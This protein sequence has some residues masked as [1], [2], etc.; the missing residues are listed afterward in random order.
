[1][2]TYRPGFAPIGIPPEVRDYVS[3]E[4]RKIHEALERAYPGVTFDFRHVAPER[5]NAGDVFLADGTNWNPG[6]GV[7]LYR[8]NAANTAWVFIEP[9][10]VAAA[11]TA[12]LADT[13][14]AHDASAI[15][16]VPAGTI[17]ATDVQAAINELDGDLTAHLA[18]ATDAH[19]ASAISSVPAGDLAATDVQAALNELDSEKQP[20]DAT[21]TA[22]AAANWAANALP[23]GTGADTLA[24]TSFA[25][26]T[27]PARSSAGNLEAKTITDFGLSIIDDAAASDARTTLGLVI[28]TDVQAYDAD[29]LSWAGV[30]RA[31]GFDTFTATPSSANLLALLT[32]ETGSG[33]AV[34][35][36]SPT[37]SGATLDG[38]TNLTGGQIAFPATQSASS[39]ANTLD[40]YEEGTWTPVLTFGTPGDLSVTYSSQAGTYTKIGRQVTVIWNITTSAF[41]HTT[42]SGTCNV[43]GLPFTNNATVSA[44]GALTWQGITKAGYTDIS[45]QV[46]TSA[47]VITM[48]ACASAS[49]A[50]VV[51]AADMPTGGSVILRGTL[52]Y[53]V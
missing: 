26:N 38:T 43:T 1:L 9:T 39:D 42:A 15:S 2:S 40:D 7:G 46:F 21:L 11:L 44:T 31:S 45:A 8:R 19:D 32:D 34:F 16:N 25:A 12:H 51:A 5:F 53:H 52:T 10:T 4:L 28:G 6:E 22:L 13:V 14:D 30:T 36:T 27:F 3:R 33:A 29:L 35:G 37:L 23:I 47:S 17:A 41:T 50:S 48:R 49:A 18:D 20:L 24:Q